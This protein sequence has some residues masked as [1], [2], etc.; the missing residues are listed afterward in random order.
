VGGFDR[1]GRNT[2]IGGALL[3][4]SLAVA[5]V[6]IVVSLKTGSPEYFMGFSI[7]AAALI[8]AGIMM[9]RNDLLTGEGRLLL[10]GGERTVTAEVLGVTRNLRRAGDKTSYFVICRYKDPVTGK[11]ETFSSRELDEYPGKEVIGREVTV[12]IDPREKGNY[13]VEIDAL[14]NEIAKEK[15]E[16]E[17]RDG[18][19]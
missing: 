14:L 13:T 11:E 10:A 9:V 19:H 4:L 15:E 2:L 5:A 6:G 8:A 12:H 1:F 18:M 17:Q 16:N 7:P 3:L